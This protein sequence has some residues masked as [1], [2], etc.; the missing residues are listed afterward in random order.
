MH[1]APAAFGSVL[2]RKLKTILVVWIPVP[3]VSNS[4]WINLVSFCWSLDLYLNA[5]PITFMVSSKLNEMRS[6]FTQKN[7]VWRWSRFQIQIY[8]ETDIH[9]QL[10]FCKKID[11]TLCLM[12]FRQRRWDLQPSSSR[13][14]WWQR[15]KLLH[16]PRKS[17]ACCKLG[18]WMWIHRLRLQGVAKNAGEYWTSVLKTR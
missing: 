4:E 11:C 14:L 6:G 10:K 15:S 9:L 8:I 2:K 12:C 17:F 7:V 18:F 13:H 1:T 16:F 3:L 5:V